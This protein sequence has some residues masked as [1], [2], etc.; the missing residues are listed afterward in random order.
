MSVTIASKFTQTY[1][2]SRLCYESIIAL[3][4]FDNKVY[5]LTLKKYYVLAVSMFEITR[6]TVHIAAEFH[7]A[8]MYR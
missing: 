4:M 7:P 5:L 2:S 6:C 8:P 1:M 3:Y